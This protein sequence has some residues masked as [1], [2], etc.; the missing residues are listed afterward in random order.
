MKK[1]YQTQA[2]GLQFA[3]GGA[4]LIRGVH[5]DIKLNSDVLVRVAIYRTK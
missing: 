1:C 2:L 4:T 5:R 3:A